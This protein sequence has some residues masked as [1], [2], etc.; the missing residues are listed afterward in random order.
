MNRCAIRWLVLGILTIPTFA[1]ATCHRRELVVLLLNLVRPEEHIAADHLHRAVAKN[2]LQRDDI[3]AAK[4][5]LLGK[6]MPERVRAAANIRDAGQSAVLRQL[7]L[8]RGSAVTRAS[9]RLLHHP[10]QQILGS[11]KRGFSS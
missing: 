3:A 5:P 1:G 2:S 7:H 11:A 8:K 4:Q 10:L 9:C 6:R